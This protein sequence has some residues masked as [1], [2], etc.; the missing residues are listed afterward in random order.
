MLQHFSED[1]SYRLHPNV[2]FVPGANR[3]ESNHVFPYTGGQMTAAV[4]D[5][6]IVDREIP[7]RLLEVV[8]FSFAAAS[9]TT[10]RMRRRK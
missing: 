7:T 2:L 4:R 3:R 10:P 1:R 9:I 8:T 5:E 6:Q